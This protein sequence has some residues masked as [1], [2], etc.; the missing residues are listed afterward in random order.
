MIAGR[1]DIGRFKTASPATKIRA[2]DFCIGRDGIAKTQN[3]TGVALNQVALRKQRAAFATKYNGRSLWIQLPGD[4][5]FERIL[6]GALVL[7]AGA[8]IAYGLWSMLDYVQNWSVINA[9]VARII[10][11]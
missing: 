4:H 2:L 5:W 8:A 3:A 7:A 10:S 9:W 1:T 6:L 11:S